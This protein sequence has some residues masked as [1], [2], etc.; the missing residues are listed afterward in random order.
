ML[1]GA[2]LS[3]VYD[4]QY[5]A[6][7]DAPSG[8]WTWFH[9]PRAVEHNGIIYFGYVKGDGDVAVRTI[10]ATTLAVSAETVLHAAL[11]AD[12]HNNPTILIRAGDSRVVVFYSRHSGA[13][14]YM[15]AS[16]NPEDISA[17]GAEINLDSS[18]GGAAYTYPSPV[19]LTTETDDPIYLFFR[20]PV[21]VNTTAM[22]RSTSTDGGATWSA[23]S[24]IY[25]DSGRSAYWKVANNGTDRID[26]AVSDGHPFYDSSVRIGHF[27]YTGGAYYRTDGTAMGAPPFD[28]ADVSQIH[29]GTPTSWVWDVAVDPVT[30][31]P[32]VT[33]VRW[34]ALNDAR[35]YWARWTG[36]AWEAHEVAAGGATDLDPVTGH[37]Y[38]GGIVLDH[39][40]PDVVYASRE[41]QG[42]FEMFRYTTADNG[43]TWTAEQLTYRSGGVNIRPVSIR[44]HGPNLAALWMFAPLYSTYE[45]YSAGTRGATP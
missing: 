3:P 43:S 4:E 39:E 8:G 16:T 22:R 2:S 10:D 12:D 6:V 35:L 45:T 24:L 20:D 11:Q 1:F 40:D 13:E 19:Q 31:H 32:R 44:N 9:E 38:T 17:F 36:A 26:F 18:L 41:V 25:S 15:R 21:D 30:G 27:Y 14:L 28:F 33:Y 23:Q 7:T 5:V 37:Y 29:A 42:Q 34:P